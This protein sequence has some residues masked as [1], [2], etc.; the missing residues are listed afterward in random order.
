MLVKT[1]GEVEEEEEK[2]VELEMEEEETGGEGDAKGDREG[3]EDFSLLVA[4]KR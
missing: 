1:D 3:V 4:D 2:E